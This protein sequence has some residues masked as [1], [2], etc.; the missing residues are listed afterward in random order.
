MNRSGPYSLDSKPR[1]GSK[2]DFWRWRHSCFRKVRFDTPES[3]LGKGGKP[4]C[5]RFCGKWHLT[6][7][8]MP[9]RPGGRIAKRAARNLSSLQGYDL[10]T[11][12]ELI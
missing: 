6:A 9:P 4:Y 12:V 5:C 7:N 10:R 1:S 3:A 11:N 8:R 2:K